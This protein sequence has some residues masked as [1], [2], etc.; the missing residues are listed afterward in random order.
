M[1]L[2]VC[3]QSYRSTNQWQNFPSVLSHFIPQFIHLLLNL[4]DPEMQ[5]IISVVSGEAPVKPLAECHCIWAPF[6]A[7]FR[8]NNIWPQVDIPVEESVMCTGRMNG[9]H[10]GAATAYAWLWLQTIAWLVLAIQVFLIRQGDGARLTISLSITS[11]VNILT[12]E[13]QQ[14]T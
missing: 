4:S 12:V 1:I 9:W 3:S 6:K 5:D 11:V 14:L 13:T 8:G 10:S 2:I 7:F